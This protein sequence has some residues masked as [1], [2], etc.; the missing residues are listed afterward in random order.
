LL[1]AS[2]GFTAVAAM[3]LFFSS[4]RRLFIRIFARADELREISRGM[5]RDDSFRSGMRFVALL[6]FVV[7]AVLWIAFFVA[8]R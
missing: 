6:Q 2:I 5:P 7:A 1:F 8:C 4:R 3:T